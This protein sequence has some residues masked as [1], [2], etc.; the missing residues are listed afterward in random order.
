MIDYKLLDALNAVLDQGGFERGARH[1]GL[2][3]S[4]VSQ[5]IKLLE[6]RL[7]QPVLVR[8]PRLAPTP[9]GRKLL[10]HAQQVRLLESDLLGEVPALKIGRASCRKECRY[11]RPACHKK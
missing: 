2:T 6:A 1:L 8:S 4:A 9:L 7:G 5:R 3:Q 10:N 11:R